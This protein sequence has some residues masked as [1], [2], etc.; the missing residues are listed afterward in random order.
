M[1]S[2]VTVVDPS[3]THVDADVEVGQDTVVEP[4]SILRGRTRI[5]AHCRIGPFCSLENA[6]VGNESEVRMSQLKDCRVLEKCVIGPYSNIRPESVIGPRAK[7]GNFCE[8]KASRV[9]FGSKVPHLS[10]VGDTDIREDVNV[11]AG[12]ITCNYDGKIKHKTTIEAKA[13][14]GSGTMMVAPVRIGKGSSTGAGAVVIRDVPDGVTVV[15]VPAKPL[16]KAG[17]KS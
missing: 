8:V 4:F 6:Q 2:G 15:G 12:S 16:V 9:G 11:G 10:Y 5:G 14:I 17:G 3:S 7:V 1:L 13:F